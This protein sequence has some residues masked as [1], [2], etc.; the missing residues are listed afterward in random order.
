MLFYHTKYVIA[1]QKQI[2]KLQENNDDNEDL[3]LDEE[4]VESDIAESE[5]ETPD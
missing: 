2:R 1:Q 4:P 3:G 5:P